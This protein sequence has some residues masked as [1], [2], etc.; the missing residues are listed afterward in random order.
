M[1]EQSPQAT[2]DLTKGVR[3]ADLADGAMIVG[4]VGDAEVLLAR[5]GDDFF[6]VRAHCTHYRGPLVRGILVG[7]TV[8]CPLHHA[9]FSLRTGEALRAPALDPLV[10]WRVERDGDRIVVRDKAAPAPAQ[11]GSASTAK[12]SSI[13]IVGGGAAGVAAAEMLRRQGYDGPVTM[14]SADGDLPV[15]RPNLSK[16]YLA[17]EAQDDW[18]PLWPESFYA[19]QRI[20]L[21]LNKRVSAIDTARRTIRLDDGTERS[22]GALLLATGADPVRVEIPGANHAD[23]LLLRSFADSRAI[24]ERT[25]GAQRVVVVGA[26]FIGL[27]VAA[28][29]R[30]RGIAVD[31]VAPESMPLERVLGADVGRYV[32][33][34]HEAKGVVFHLGQTVTR[35]DG[36]TVTL[37]GGETL[38]CDFVVMGVGV[39]PALA[40]AEQAGLKLDRGIEVNEYLETS[41]PGVFA[42]GD[43]A[44]WPDPHTGERIR[45]EH[46][47]VAER[48]GQVAARNMLGARERFDAVPFFWSLHYDTSIRYVGH[49]DKWDDVQITGS[50]D[51]GDCAVAYRRGGRTL[52]LATIGRDRE[53]LEAEVR[54]EQTP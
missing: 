24:V 1:S 37:S 7:D 54:M 20:E 45:V 17:G 30:N 33:T 42:A 52:A 41:A 48:Q 6:A 16:D 35:V 50:L 53:N 47:V 22:Y 26:S 3:A 8:R 15:D 2:I 13:V 18:I 34:L 51:G 11:S 29:L 4:R 10:C 21:L 14:I 32:R 40:L 39:R 49:A 31:V 28:S 25:A 36:R 38:D 5:S 43:V 12:P 9:C 46:W 27:E 19:E 44:R 23:V